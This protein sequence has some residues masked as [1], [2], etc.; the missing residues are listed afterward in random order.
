MARKK[1]I[2][3][4]R[5]FVCFAALLLL[6]ALAT[7]AGATVT[8]ARQTRIEAERNVLHAHRILRRL[9]R[10]LVDAR[11]GLPRTDTTVVCRGRGRRVAGAWP[12]FVCTISYHRVHV[13]VLY[14][15]QR[16]NG[17]ELHRLSRRR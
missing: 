13:A 11:T 3:M 14:D 2:A 7:E 5:G 12:R 17:F 6:M 16:R 8:A 15:A 4:T 10:R 9:D 1:R